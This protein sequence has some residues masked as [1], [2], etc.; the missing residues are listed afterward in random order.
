MQ[1]LKWTWARR[2]SCLKVIGLALLAAYFFQNPFSVELYWVAVYLVIVIG[3]GGAFALVVHP[4]IERFFP[5]RMVDIDPIG[6]RII[7]DVKRRPLS[8][9]LLLP[10][11]DGFFFVPLLWFGITPLTAAISAAAFAAVHYPQFPLRSCIVKFVFIFCIAV[12]V[13]PHGLGSVLV[14]HLVLDAVAFFV[15]GKLFANTPA[16]GPRDA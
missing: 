10:G 15:G 16:S 11:E 6:A 1:A 14:G 12:V 2:Y 3:I 13:L 5:G 7:N 8:F 4:L 9:L